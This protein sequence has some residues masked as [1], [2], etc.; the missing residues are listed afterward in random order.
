VLLS[1]FKS[2]RSRA[3]APRATDRFA[4]ALAAC[5]AEKL[6]AHEEDN[7]DNDRWRGGAAEMEPQEQILGRYTLEDLLA[8]SEQYAL[9]HDL[10]EDDRSRELYVQL[11]AFRLLGHNHVRLPTNCSEHWEARAR[12]KAMPSRPVDLAG[13]FAF[14]G[15]ELDFEGQRVDIEGSVYGIMCAFGLRQ[16]YYDRR[17]VTI[18]PRKG[19]RV[20][21]AGAFLAETALAFAASVGPEGRV[22]SFEIDPMNATIARRNFALNPGLAQRIELH[23]CALASDKTPLY[24]VGGGPAARVSTEP[25]GEP[26]KVETIDSFIDG[27]GL[28]R[29][30]FIKMDIEGAEPLA[31]AGA[32]K[33]LRRYRPALAISIY[34]RP[35]DL[36]SIALQL[37]R[38][39][40]GYR[41]YLDHYTIHSEETVL[42]AIA[43]RRGI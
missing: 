6:R 15:Y 19:D 32:E 42:Y 41:F 17:G 11:V 30:D 5:V 33:T 7:V 27:G 23:E 16:Y 26:L 21:D 29:V 8:N 39:G 14:A 22:A 36:W 20:I 37:D 4:T 40:I 34:H 3:P 28:D 38:L 13:Y 18:R 1:L 31:L 24:R 10:F 2:I 9:A 12:I 35:T 25:V 43:D